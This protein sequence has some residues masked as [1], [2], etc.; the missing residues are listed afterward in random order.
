[1]AAIQ[2]RVIAQAL[3]PQITTLVGENLRRQIWNAGTGAVITLDLTPQV[4]AELLG[5]GCLAI[6]SSMNGVY[7]PTYPGDYS[8]GT[9]GWGT[10]WWT[11]SIVEVNASVGVTLQL[12]NES[13]APVANQQ[14]I[15]IYQAGTGQATIAGDTGVTLRSDGGKV[16]TAA[17][18][19]TVG[20]RRRAA[21]EWVVSGD[22]A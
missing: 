15:E 1:M 10:G 12:P 14:M 11:N 2:Y 3:G 17:Q 7:A 8:S 22:L 13:N 19:A 5:R 6:W 21:N 9:L 4:Q 18:Y 20:L 16:K